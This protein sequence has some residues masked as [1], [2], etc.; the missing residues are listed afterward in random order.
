MSEVHDERA[1]DSE[2]AREIGP[3]EPRTPMWLPAAG[4]VLLLIGASCWI[5]MNRDE[6]PRRA[7]SGS[8]SA[9]APDNPAAGNSAIPSAPRP[10]ELGAGSQRA[11]PM[12]ERAKA[13]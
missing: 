9:P 13:P 7:T 10:G 11:R 5:G 8:T 3:D 4:V 12:A 6:P 2:P 1:F